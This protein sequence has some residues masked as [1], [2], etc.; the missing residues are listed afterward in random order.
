MT[1][2]EQTRFEQLSKEIVNFV[3]THPKTQE[4]IDFVKYELHLRCVSKDFLQ[5]I[6]E[7]KEP[8]EKFIYVCYD[9]GK[10]VNYV[11][12]D[13]ECEECLK[14]TDALRNKMFNS[15]KTGGKRDGN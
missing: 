13:H 15:H 1:T 14:E 12:S 8:E 10:S 9:C 5:K 4:C 7:Q 2:K 11:N 6:S 3:Q